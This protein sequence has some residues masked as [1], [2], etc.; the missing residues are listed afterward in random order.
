VNSKFTI[1]AQHSNTYPSKTDQLFLYCQTATQE[2][3]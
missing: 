2:K 1:P 3:D